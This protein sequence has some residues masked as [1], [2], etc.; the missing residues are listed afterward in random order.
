MAKGAIGFGLVGV[1]IFSA[2]LVNLIIN[3]AFSQLENIIIA[4]ICF[5]IMILGIVYAM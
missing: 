1:F 5:T 4:S 2:S 3:S